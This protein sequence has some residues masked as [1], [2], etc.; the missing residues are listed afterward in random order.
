MLPSWKSFGLA[1]PLASPTEATLSKK[2]T[3]TLPH[4]NAHA[5]Q[6]ACKPLQSGQHLMCLIEVVAAGIDP[7]A[8][9]TSYALPNTKSAHPSHYRG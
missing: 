6:P 2:K 4:R 9:P 3:E 7:K 8:T 1:E 5:I